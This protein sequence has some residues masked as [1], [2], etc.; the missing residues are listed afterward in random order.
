MNA[1]TFSGAKPTSQ[2]ACR[3]HF[4]THSRLIPNY[5][6]IKHPDLRFSTLPISTIQRNFTTVHAENS[7]VVVE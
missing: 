3:V 1:I 6:S 4:F 2:G 5:Q 7:E